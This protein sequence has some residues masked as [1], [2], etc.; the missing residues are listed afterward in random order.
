LGVLKYPARYTQVRR[1]DLPPNVDP[2]RLRA[3]D[4]KPPKCYLDTEEDV[5]SWLLEPFS[6]AD[7]TR[8]Q[9][10][11]KPTRTQHGKPSEI[12]LDTSIMELADDI[13]YGV[14]D[15][16]DAITLG[17]VTESHW[18]SK[19]KEA[20]DVVWA[21]RVGLPDFEELQRRLFPNYGARKRTIGSLVHAI[22]LSSTLSDR[23]HYEH[24]L[25][26]NRVIVDEPA[27]R[28]LG[29][30]KSLVHERVV[31]TPNVQMLEYRGQQVVMRIFGVYQSDPHRFLKPY[32]AK[33]C[34]KA[35]DEASRMRVICDYV[36]GMTDEYAT[37]IYER[38]FM[39]RE[40]TVFERL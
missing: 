10:F 21:K 24:P 11:R 31:R 30:L 16:E 23:A 27:E 3:E 8:F 35:P 18:R 9:S 34:E 36:A 28:F 15:L 37:R 22:I 26:R 25:L 17:L 38:L 39:P 2:E 13:A 40:G 6:S 20:I 32:Y 12:A 5:V 7:R 29:A 33:L 19:M 14:H 1:S 4:W